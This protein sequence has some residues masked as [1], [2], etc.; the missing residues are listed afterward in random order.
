MKK[1]KTSMS[2]PTKIIACAA[3]VACVAIGIAGLILPIIP[4]VVF[5]AVAVLICARLSP[6]LDARLR[7]HRGM[8]R[9]LD[10]SDAFLSLSLPAQVQVAALYCVKLLLDSLAFLSSLV[11]KLRRA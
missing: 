9:H 11:A 7:R 8:R 3:V 4:G 1:A 6:W 10:R 5:L 2:L